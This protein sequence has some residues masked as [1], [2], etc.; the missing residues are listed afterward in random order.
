MKLGTAV[1][2]AMIGMMSINAVA[3]M[4]NEIGIQGVPFQSW[5]DDQQTQ[6]L[7]VTSAVDSLESDLS[8]YDMPRGIWGWWNRFVYLFDA[9]P[10]L[11]QLYRIPTFIYTPLYVIWKSIQMIFLYVVFIGGRDV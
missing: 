5:D 2:Y 4:L 9:F 3:I 11:L 8:F 10:Q 6:A 7:N 1:V